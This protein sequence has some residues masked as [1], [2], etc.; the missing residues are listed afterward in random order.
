MPLVDY[1]SESEDESVV[2]SKRE[3][4]KRKRSSPRSAPPP[5]PAA[6]HDL[7]ASSARTSTRD[8]PS[9]HGGRK[10][11]IPH[12]EGN[13]PSHIYL[14][15]KCPRILF[16]IQ[17]PLT[18]RG[19]PSAEVADLIS[20]LVQETKRT[21]ESSEQSKCLHLH[22]LTTSDLGVA[23]PL[24]ISLSCS[25]PLATEQRQPFLNELRSSLVLKNIRPFNA[26]LDGL[27]WVS[28]HEKTRWFLVLSI[29]PPPEDELNKLLKACNAVSGSYGFPLLYEEPLEMDSKR[30]KSTSSQLV[31]LAS[32][33][34]R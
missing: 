10:R 15:C 32:W 19:R 14:E 22:S 27:R 7:Y 11:A 12:V 8:D 2:G 25:L 34:R 5:P 20:Q 29:K 33:E 31:A 17:T 3:S 26:A 1:S 9:L 16:S 21:L 23:S 30:L 18:R 4:L 13:W 24:H 6:F 28:N